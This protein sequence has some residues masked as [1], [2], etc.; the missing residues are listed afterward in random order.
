MNSMF[1]NCEKL[2][3]INFVK[4]KAPKLLDIMY[5]FKNCE[6][7]ISIDLSNFEIRR[8]YMMDGLFLNCK[9]LT[10][11]NLSNLHDYIYHFFYMDNLFSGCVNLEYINLQNI[12]VI[13]TLQFE[14]IFRDIPK[15]LVICLSQENE[16]KFK[17]LMNITNNENCYTIYCGDDWIKHQKKLINGTN[18]CINSCNNSI[19]YEFEFNG[20]CYNSC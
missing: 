12:R 13:N 14:E 20:K 17:E 9:S 3:S 5:L 7:L 19:N 18:T 11:I 4:S 8:F 16:E 15:N 6:S 2:I 1:E 10:S